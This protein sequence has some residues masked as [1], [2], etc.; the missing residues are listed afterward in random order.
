M[1]QINQKHNSQ[2]N[3]VCCYVAFSLIVFFIGACAGN[4][5]ANQSAITAGKVAQSVNG[6]ASLIKFEQ[7]RANQIKW[8][9]SLHEGMS[10]QNALRQVSSSLRYFFQYLS[11][12]KIY[13]YMEGEYPITQMRFGLLFEDGMLTNLIFDKAVNDFI[14]Y[15]YNYAREWGHLFQ[16]WLPNGFQES[17]S[18]IRGQNRI[19]DN[20]D[21]VSNSYKQ[22]MV[23]DGKESKVTDAIITSLFLAPFMPAVLM[24]MPF[25]PKDE[26]AVKSK[27]IDSISDDKKK[28]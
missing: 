23:I 20:Y 8:L 28:T 25:V 10:P 19:G 24:V 3:T 5:T 21:D 22:E 2:I 15:R 1:E 11:N 12:G 17:I 16:H 7:Y 18:F 26:R 9:S 14:W 4:Q 13:Q 6:T 27:E